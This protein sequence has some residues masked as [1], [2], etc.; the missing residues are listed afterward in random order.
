MVSSF[1]LWI[2]NQSNIKYQKSNIYF[3]TKLNVPLYYMLWKILS[4]NPYFQ[5]W[6]CFVDCMNLMV[7][8]TQNQ[9]YYVCIFFPIVMQILHIH[10]FMNALNDAASYTDTKEWTI[11][12]S[13]SKTAATIYKP[14]ISFV[15]VS[16]CRM[17]ST[18]ECLIIIK[19]RWIY[20][21]FAQVLIRSNF[22]KTFFFFANY[23]RHGNPNSKTSLQKF[24]NHKKN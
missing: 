8:P 11:T 24:E 15:R 10:D 5:I 1:E 23:C 2:S 17:H 16:E 20:I 21:W 14:V 3:G 18:V 12:F 4:S 9:W 19:P 22:T 13:N 7:S 6:W